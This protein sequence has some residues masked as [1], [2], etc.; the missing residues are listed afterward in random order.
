M[1]KEIHKPKMRFRINQI[2]KAAL[3]GSVHLLE[4]NTP[5]NEFQ[6]LLYKLKEGLENDN[7]ELT[8]VLALFKEGSKIGH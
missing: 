2:I 6:I 8:V 5:N 3:M 7:E 4:N 1:K